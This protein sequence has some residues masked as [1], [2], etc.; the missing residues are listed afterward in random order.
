MTRE[1][2]Q[3][4]F[5][6]CTGLL[7]VR[8]IPQGG[9]VVQQFRPL[10][11]GLDW[12]DRWG[13]DGRV[14]VYFGVY[15]RTRSAGTANAVAPL[16]SWVYADLDASE[17]S[18]PQVLAPTIVV[19]SGSPGH[20]H[21]YWHLTEPIAIAEAER[22]NKALADVLGGD[23]NATDRARVLR[24]PGTI[25]SKTGC[26]AVVTHF[27]ADAVYGLRDFAA[28]LPPGTCK[29][30]GGGAIQPSGA[31]DRASSGSAPP[32]AARVLRKGERN[33]S[34][35]RLAG[36]MRRA[37][38]QPEEILP[39]LLEV[40][41]RRCR[42]LLCEAEVAKIARGI[43]RYAPAVELGAGSPSSLSPIPGDDDDDAPPVELHTLPRPGPREW[44]VTDL[45]P[46]RAVT[47]FYGDGGLAKSLIA[48]LLGDRITRGQDLFGRRVQQS[49]VLYLDWELDQEEQARRAYRVAAGLGYPSPAPGLFYRQMVLPLSES[50]SQIRAWVEDLRTSFVVLDSFGLAT[51]GDPTTARDVAPLLAAVSRL[52]CTSCFVDH[53]RNLQQGEKPEDLRPFGSVYK[54]NIARSVIRATRVDGDDVSLSVL[55]RQTKS[56]F[57]A[58]SEPL[59]LKLSF[60][61]ERVAFEQVPLS[62]ASFAHATAQLGACERVLEALVVA[63]EASAPDL[64]SATGLA[65]GT[66]KNQLTRLRN[67]G[68]AAPTSR[69]RWQPAA[70]SSSSLPLSDGDDDERA[71]GQ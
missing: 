27:D 9:D 43:G 19:E 66:V 5:A 18:I 28:V 30:T 41:R 33:I 26:E 39:G 55:L 6:G 16:V 61:K 21:V 2:L 34:L 62:S 40:N 46:A 50:L 11:D 64:A 8:H 56:N 48:M 42:P 49:P 54:F 35:T 52:P 68:K 63:E 4:L 12:V 36:T 15:P 3:T 53:V 32:T 69:G 10:E 71:G 24:L 22:L 70:S 23:T 44:V 20:R 58:L 47:V 13:P 60:E 25:N 67:E 57:S 1:F 65:L 45:I 31:T 37:G 14:D 7:E 17:A 51:V 38:M 29:P 59:G